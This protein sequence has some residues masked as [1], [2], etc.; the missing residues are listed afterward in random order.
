[1]EGL[2]KLFVIQIILYLFGW[3]GKSGEQ[4]VE[5]INHRFRKL[6][7]YTPPAKHRGYRE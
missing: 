1:M 7:R 4:W 6:F 3:L 2:L 5:G